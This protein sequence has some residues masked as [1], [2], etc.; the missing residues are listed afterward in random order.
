MRIIKYTEIKYGEN[1]GNVYRLSLPNFHTTISLLSNTFIPLTD[2]K[3]S[4]KVE[5]FN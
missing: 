5:A 4:L 1:R 3:H 2:V